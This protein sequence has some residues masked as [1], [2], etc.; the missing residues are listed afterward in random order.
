M[1]AGVVFGKGDIRY[2]DWEEPIAGKGEV[3]VRVKA[4][5][6]CGSDV[7]R[8]L[9]DEAHFYPIILGHEF[10]G[11]IDAVGPGVDNVT[12]GDHVIGI[13]LIPCMQCENCLRGDYALCTNY[14]FVGSRRPGAFA[15][16]VVLPKENV[17]KIDPKIPFDVAALFEPS[18]VALHGLRSVDF[19]PGKRVAVLGIGAIGVFVVQWA[20]ILGAREIIAMDVADERLSLA[21]KVGA[22]DVVNTTRQ[23]TLPT[24]FDYVFETAGQPDTIKLGF[25]LVGPKC[26]LCCIGTPHRDFEFPW[27]VWENMNRREARVNGTWMSYSAPFPGE[28]WRLTAEKFSDHSLIFTED[29]VYDRM[30]MSEITKAFDLYKVPGQVKGRIILQNE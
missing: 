12:V 5:G 17:V 23:E 2:T 3:R 10:S 6:I 19:Q 11:V 8:A 29:I 21:M 1:K 30:P 18:T 24:G 4:C 22:T 27:K 16:Y 7:P 9:G 26:S 13:P 15:D 25:R 20:R 14:S 28:E